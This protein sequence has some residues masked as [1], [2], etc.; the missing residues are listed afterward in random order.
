MKYLILIAV[1][2]MTGCTSLQYAGSSAY[3]IRQ[4]I[5]E[6]GKTGFDIT[7]KNGKEIALVKAHLEKKG[8]DFTVDLEEQGVAAFAGQQISADAL[9]IT[10]EQAAKAAVSA[11]L[12]AVM[13]ASLSTVG[14]IISGGGVGAGLLGAGVGAAGVIGAQKALAPKPAEAP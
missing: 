9:K 10:A 14:D 6:N 11:A 3:S 2:L 13:P 5:D 4:V 7:V 12:A 8:E 1:V